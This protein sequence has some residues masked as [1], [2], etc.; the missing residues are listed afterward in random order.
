[1]PR[2]EN[3]TIGPPQP[4]LFGGESMRFVP[5]SELSS[6]QLRELPRAAFRD[7]EWQEISPVD[8]EAIYEGDPESKRVIDTLTTELVRHY[9]WAVGTEDIWEDAGD[10]LEPWFDGFLADRADELAVLAGH[11]YDEPGDLYEEYATEYTADQVTAAL[12]EALADNN[13]YEY[14]WSPYSEGFYY[15]EYR[16]ML[17]LESDE[18]VSWFDAQRRPFLD[19]VER[20]V[21]A[22]NEEIGFAYHWDRNE[23]WDIISE[24]KT[25][26]GFSKPYESGPLE[27]DF[28]AIATPVWGNILADARADLED[29]PRQAIVDVLEETPDEERKVCRFD[30]GSYVLHLAASQLPAEGRALGHCIGRPQHKYLGNVQRGEAD[31]YSLRTQSGRPKFTF[32]IEADLVE[33]VKGKGNRLPGWDRGKVGTGKFK[34][35]EVEKLKSCLKQLGHNPWDVDDMVPGLQALAGQTVTRRGNPRVHCAFCN[36]PATTAR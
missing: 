19:E 30:D 18:I 27:T 31:A 34:P 22:A 24:P 33:E 2:R 4:D 3:P 9:N 17:Y 26:R 28:Y 8:A 35:V 12:N 15:V 29:R 16:P 7:D 25:D 1:M 14:Q 10:Y 32:Y 5:L 36:R 6:E 21:D 20:A 23:L 11:Q 13:N